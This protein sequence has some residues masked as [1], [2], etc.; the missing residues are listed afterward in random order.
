MIF[1]WRWSEDCFAA[2]FARSQAK[3]RSNARWYHSR[4]SGLTIPQAPR[5]STI[6]VA[7]PYA[8][9]DLIAGKV[10]HAQATG[11]HEPEARAVH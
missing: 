4:S 8:D 3:A 10:F 7:F 1:W 9:D 5:T 6:F 11:F 2:L